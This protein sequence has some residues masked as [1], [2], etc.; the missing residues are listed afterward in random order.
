[1]Q[2]EFIWILCTLFLLIINL[3]ASYLVL[4]SYHYESKRAYFFTIIWH[5]CVIEAFRSVNKI[6]GI[7]LSLGLELEENHC[8]A[9]CGI[10]GTFD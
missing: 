10:F 1:M 2:E 7:V 4:N 8:S 6:I 3:L 5:M 9:Y